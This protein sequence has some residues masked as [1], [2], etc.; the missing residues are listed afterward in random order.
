MPLDVTPQRHDPSNGADP[1]WVHALDGSGSDS[2]QFHSWLLQDSNS[3]NEGDTA[4][5]NGVESVA[6]KHTG[7]KYCAAVD[8]GVDFQCYVATKCIDVQ[9]MGLFWVPVHTFALLR[10]K[11]EL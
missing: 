8:H 2:W 11:G 5:V 4:I 1:R 7:C 6:M 9:N 3:V 10:L